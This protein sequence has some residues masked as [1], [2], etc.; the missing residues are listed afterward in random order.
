MKKPRNSRVNINRHRHAALRGYAL[1]I[2]D[3]K[4][5]NSHEQRPNTVKSASGSPLHAREVE[6]QGVALGPTP[7]RSVAGT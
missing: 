2:K 3:S 1:V 6:A 5:W 4:G 7:W